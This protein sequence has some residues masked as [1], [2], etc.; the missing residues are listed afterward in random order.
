MKNKQAKQMI[1]DCALNGR[2]LFYFG[3]YSEKFIAH[4]IDDVFE[5]NREWLDN[6]EIELINEA[7]EF[8]ELPLSKSVNY[9]F[10]PLCWNDDLGKME[11]LINAVN[12]SG[13]YQVS[14]AYI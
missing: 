5:L 7:G 3:E 10:K 9:W 12:E 4:S 1:L 8:G 14:T 11:P 2:K 6:G 13:C